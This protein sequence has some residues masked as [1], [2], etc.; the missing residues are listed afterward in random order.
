MEEC[1]EI[2]ARV[3]EL[4]LEQGDEEDDIQAWST[5]IEN[6]LEE[7]ERAVKGLEELERSLR[8][9][10]TRKNQ[11]EE[12]RSRWGFKKKFAAKADEKDNDAAGKSIAKL[13]ELVITKFQGTH[14]YWQRLWGQCEAEIDN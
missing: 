1:H 7:Y 3:Q 13:P 6:S 5:G 4:K 12:E 10:E 14:L 8:E 11:E 2:K 9:Q